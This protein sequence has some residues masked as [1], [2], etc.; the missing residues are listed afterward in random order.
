MTQATDT[1]NGLGGRLPLLPPV[2]LDERQR[3]V[4]HAL[5]RPRGPHRPACACTSAG[6]AN[7]P[8]G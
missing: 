1:G 3:T 8:S 6:R 5:T 2:T 7:G 4:Y